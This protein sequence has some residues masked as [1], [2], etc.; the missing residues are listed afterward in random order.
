M[1]Q[2]QLEIEVP[3]STLIIVQEVYIPD[4]KS[5]NAN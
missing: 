3:N 2:D 4:S 1:G 5:S